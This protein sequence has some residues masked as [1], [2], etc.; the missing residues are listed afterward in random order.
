MAPG[1]LTVLKRPPSL[2]HLLFGH[3]F[4]LESAAVKSDK[5]QNLDLASPTA[6][7]ARV[8]LRRPSSSS[9]LTAR[10]AY[11]LLSLPL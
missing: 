11:G 9:L 10:R 7:K 8:A 1:R 3:C 6:R 2:L 4:L 5:V